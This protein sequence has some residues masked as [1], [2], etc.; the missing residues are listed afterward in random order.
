[1]EPE[2]DCENTDRNPIRRIVSLC[3]ASAGSGHASLAQT[4]A[5]CKLLIEKGLIT[6]AE[7]MQK[8]RAESGAYQAMVQ[9]LNVGKNLTSV[10]KG[11][12]FLE[13]P[14]GNWG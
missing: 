1:M 9:K 13:P 3:C 5:L 7:F 6:E 11:N 4:D 10:S 14:E 8:P 12:G 2:C